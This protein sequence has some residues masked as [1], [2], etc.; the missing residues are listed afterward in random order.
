MG[1]CVWGG[2]SEDV[3]VGR[4]EGEKR[5]GE[6]G[7]EGELVPREAELPDGEIEEGWDERGEECPEDVRWKKLETGGGVLGGR[8]PR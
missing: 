6:D 8:S 2:V 4:G 5:G 1:Q 3:V 7:E